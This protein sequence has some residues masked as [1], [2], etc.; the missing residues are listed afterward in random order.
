MDIFILACN[1]ETVKLTE[2]KY[3]LKQSLF[4]IE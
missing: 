4:Y 1:K 2:L 3:S